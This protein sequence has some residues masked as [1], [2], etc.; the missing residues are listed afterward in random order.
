MKITSLLLCIGFLLIGVYASAQK[1]I[2]AET[3]YLVFS[4]IALII[5]VAEIIIE[6]IKNK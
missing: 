3:A 4:L 6:Q 5:G 2:Y 1:N